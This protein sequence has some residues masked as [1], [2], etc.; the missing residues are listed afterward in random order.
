MYIRVFNFLVIAGLHVACIYAQATGPVKWTR[1][2]TDTKDVSVALPAGFLVDAEKTDAG[3]THRIFAYAGATSIEARFY[4][5]RKA[6]DRAKPGRL[7]GGNIEW[8]TAEGLGGMRMC[9]GPGEH[10]SCSILLASDDFYYV[11]VVRSPSAKP[12]IATTFLSSIMAKGKFIFSGENVKGDETIQLSQLQT[13]QTVR[14]AM[15]RKLDEK[16]VNVTRR[17]MSESETVVEKA[18]LPLIRPAVIL[19]KPFPRD[20]FQKVMLSE[21]RGDTGGKVVSTPENGPTGNLRGLRAQ[22]TFLASGQ[23]GDIIIYSDEKKDYV[24]SCLDSIKKIRFVPA[25]DGE[26]PVDSVQSVS[27]TVNVMGSPF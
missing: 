5:D 12:E 3:R 22:V 16:L 25:T 15:E 26:K 11:F 9:S 1:V 18:P 10:V 21:A 23:I 27:Y 20:L 4:K 2:E 7:G 24:N 14:E 17:P 8:F 13:S 6:R 19:D